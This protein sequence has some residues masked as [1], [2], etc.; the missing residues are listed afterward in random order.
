M[1]DGELPAQDGTREWRERA[2]EFPI[3]EARR[4]VMR[5][6]G[7][8]PLIYWTDFL[9][10]ALIGWGAFAYAVT[11]AWRWP[12]YPLAVLVAGFA[13]YRAVIFIHELAHI[14]QT[15]MRAFRWA[16]NLLAGM[17]M[18]VPSFTYTR[19]HS[20]HHRPRIY[21]TAIDGEYR[22]FG[23][24]PV[25]KIVLYPLESVFLPA[26]FI[27]RF[28]VLAPLGWLIPP[29]G[30]LVW[31]RFS[32]LT[33]DLSYRRP[34]PGKG[35]D[36][37]WRIEEAMAFLFGTGVV[38]AMATGRLPWS[39]GVTWYLVAMLIFFVN[40]LRTLAAHAYRNP[41]DGAPMNRAEEFLDSVDIPGR[42]PL[43]ALWAPVGL[44][45][46]ATHHLFPSLPY[47]ELPKAHR[48]LKAELADNRLYLAASRRGLFDALRRLWRDARA[49]R[50]RSHAGYRE[51]QKR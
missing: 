49:A 36:P 19:V 10:S 4:I 43:G 32:S 7:P 16:W 38:L 8:R 2:R 51:A 46:H 22:P 39:F 11:H 12:D 14:K 29:L 18:L 3:N 9:L 31:A 48:L 21:G 35:D 6:S 41:E 26:L 44:R 24:E 25:W 1:R 47:H 45:F 37:H 30:R 23:A 40:S 42:T 27:L 5:L 34:P 50:G 33:I 20:D 17:P 28:V 15:R 13:L